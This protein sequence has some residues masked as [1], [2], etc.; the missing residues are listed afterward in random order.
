VTGDTATATPMPRLGVT[1]MSFAREIHLGLWDLDACLEQAGRLGKGTALELTGAQSLP[2]YPEL[3]PDVA[4][5]FRNGVERHGLVPT[6][7]DAYLERGR[8]FG[9]T[10]TLE[11][12]AELILAEL[13]I[14]HQL[15][16]PLLRLNAAT[17]EL[18]ALL[19]PT[20]ERLGI[21][22][23]VE[24]HGLSAR[25][26]DAVRLSEYFDAVASPSL[27][28]LQ[29]LGAMMR[30]VPSRYLE[31][32]RRKG[33]PEAAVTA[34]GL[35]WAGGRPLDEVLAHL[36]GLAAGPVAMEWAVGCFVMFH[37]NPVEELD[38]VLPH[39][40][41]VHGKFLGIDR[42]GRE[43]SIDYP[44]VIDRLRAAGYHGV[45]SSEY[46]SWAPR[47]RLDS[48][49]QVAAHHRMVRALWNQEENRY[50]RTI[51]VSASR[52]ASS[53]ASG[54]ANPGP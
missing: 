44:A 41:H 11:E 20:A 25:H 30:S 7:Y 12:A 48:Y 53:P 26:P 39:L 31:D 3:L 16:F 2:G 54:V 42:D 45:I 5:A 51:S 38:L 37:R 46:I 49:E 50:R 47:D 19:L 29:D 9:R 35:A 52:N 4:A 1:L 17:P 33:V 27:G 34:V 15:G 36:A 28:F 6:C 43:P 23:V 24:L 14:A 18:L 10:A 40:A 13:R 21:R 32:G 22:I 8:R